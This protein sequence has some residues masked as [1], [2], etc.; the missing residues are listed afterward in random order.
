MN[1]RIAQAV[2]PV[3]ITLFWLL[4]MG[5]LFYAKL[6]PPMLGSR[7]PDYVSQMPTAGKPAEPVY[8]KMIWE[9]RKIGYAANHAVATEDGA[10]MRSLVKFEE[11]ELAAMLK[12]LFGPLAAVIAPGDEKT[13]MSLQ[14]AN[15]AKLDRESNL[16]TFESVV[17]LPS[18]PR[19]IQVYGAA[20]GK[21]DFHITA[22]M[23]SFGEK[24]QM[25]DRTITL[26]PAA[27]VRDGLAPRTQMKGREI[28]QKWTV[29]VQQTFSPTQA[30]QMLEAEVT[31][32]ELIVWNG[33]TVET[34]VVVYRPEAS[35]TIGAARKPNGRVW[36]NSSG[37]VLK[38]QVIAANLTVEFE[39]MP[40]GN[41]PAGAATAI[42]E[43]FSSNF[44]TPK[45]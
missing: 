20:R 16:Q 19:M 6:L 14:V 26:P 33:K 39:R 7:A 21:G 2:F 30:M 29:P 15:R 41:A 35:S 3:A 24:Q 11:L 13:K 4:S 44:T 36:V 9:G 37:D 42:G 12:Q 5:W 27:T 40:S 31:Q 10:E 8:W 43:D 23:R 32:H 22:T 34:L 25:Y 38:Q 1:R 17:D 18:A 45:K 28:G